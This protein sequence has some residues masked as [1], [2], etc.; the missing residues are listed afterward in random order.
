MLLKGCLTMSSLF[1]FNIQIVITGFLDTSALENGE[2]GGYH[3]PPGLDR[4]FVCA[5][6]VCHKSAVRDFF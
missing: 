1:C 4:G 6:S 2:D 3:S 5:V